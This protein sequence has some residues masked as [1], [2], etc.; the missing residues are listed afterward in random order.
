MAEG[1]TAAL[2][3]SAP[4]K[5]ASVIAARN[6]GQEVYRTCCS[7]VGSI[8]S[9]QNRLH[10]VVV[11]DGSID[12]SCDFALGSEH[13]GY[14]LIR[15]DQSE[16]AGSSHNAGCQAALEDGADVVTF[17]DAHMR[18]PAGVIERL[19]AKAAQ[20]EA[21]VMSASTGM[22][23]DS[24][25]TGYGCRL[26]WSDS[27]GIEGK[28]LL[29]AP[30]GEW[31]EAAC[32]MGACYAMSRATIERLKGPTGRLWEDVAG[33]WGY[34]EEALSLKAALLGVPVLVSRDLVSRHLYR[35]E[36]P[37]PGAG[38]ERWRNITFSLAG[39]FTPETF[40][41]L[42]RAPCEK[43]LPPD[44]VEDLVGRG[45]AESSRPWTGYREL[46]VLEELV[47]GLPDLGVSVAPAQG[48]DGK[49]DV[50]VIGSGPSALKVKEWDLDGRVVVCLNNA[51]RLAPDRYDVWV[52]A[53]DFPPKS[54]PPRRL[55]HQRW[56]SH[57]E[58][59]EAALKHHRTAHEAGYTLFCLAAYW[60]LDSL[61]PWRI[62]F[63]GCDHDYDPEATRRWLAAGQPGP[64]NK[65]GG[66][67]GF[68]SS[69]P[70]MI[71]Q[72]SSGFFRD[73][74]STHFYGH[75]SPDPMRLGAETLA[76]RF[77]LIEQTSDSLGVE[78]VNY[79]DAPGLLPFRRAG[80]G[81]GEAPAAR[82]VEG[83]G[84]RSAVRSI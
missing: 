50:V 49:N 38:E 43:H 48:A 41:S 27:K 23:P 32:L 40:E 42:L 47:E 70:E 35:Q 34:A 29:D 56:I 22:A 52:H 81:A 13:V 45:R 21:I 11:D 14:R 9:D 30:G 1:G 8:L 37:V 64:Q 10:V 39:L 36:N 33:R 26:R 28:W 58:Y 31:G 84:S 19:A 15:H 44:V 12:G 51:W 20:S 46:R 65:W 59:T 62:G 68:S 63:V 79:S 83:L 66:A 2:A 74:R 6:E 73:T 3:G 78:V 25:F 75:G 24:R 77:R 54:F 67:Q 53:G 5:I 69:T 71:G 16:G 61:N 4:L 55:P 57:R 7:L 72:W 18:F 60:V 76:E 17:H 80:F 82:E